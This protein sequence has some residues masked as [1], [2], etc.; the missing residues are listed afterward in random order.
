ARVGVVQGRPDHLGVA[1]GLETDAPQIEAHRTPRAVV[2]EGR[3]GGGGRHQGDQHG[4]D[5]DSSRSKAHG[6]TLL[7][8]ESVEAHSTARAASMS[9]CRYLRIVTQS[10]TPAPPATTVTAARRTAPG[11][12]CS[13]SGPVS[14]GTG[15]A[16][17]S[18]T[19]TAA[20]SPAARGDGPVDRGP[21]G[22]RGA[23]G[24][25]ALE[26]IRPLASR[27]RGPVAA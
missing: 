23:G 13:T 15:A 9:S 3:P 19:A 16:S 27:T 18:A 25:S 8:E 20:R 10:Q 21:Q 1:L 7:S 2:G 26:S 6:G 24:A 12:P 14:A 5:G 4:E 11:A 17:G 22:D